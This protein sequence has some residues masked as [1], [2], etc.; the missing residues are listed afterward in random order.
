[1]QDDG[2]IEY[3]NNIKN[4]AFPDEVIRVNKKTRLIVPLRNMVRGP[5]QPTVPQLEAWAVADNCASDAFNMYEANDIWVQHGL[6]PRVNTCPRMIWL[7]RV[8]I[9][10]DHKIA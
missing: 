1:M 9:F 7:C 8:G 10:L 3:M 5:I 6:D 2:I 4:M